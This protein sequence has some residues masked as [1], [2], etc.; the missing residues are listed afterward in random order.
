MWSACREFRFLTNLSLPLVIAAPSI[1]LVICALA[2]ALVAYPLHL[3]FADAVD[4]QALVYKTAEIFMAL[5]LIPIGQRLG[6]GKVDIA[7]VGPFR[8]LLSQVMRGFGWGA[9][10]MG[11]HVLVLVL[12]D[13]V[14]Y[15]HLTLPT[16][17]EV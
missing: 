1:Y 15:T 6:M 4:F 7:L 16:N 12:L 10:M 9:L 8:L 2:G 17:R 13:A 11:I 5:S 3:V 14:S